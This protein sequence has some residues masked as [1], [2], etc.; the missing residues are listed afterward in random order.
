MPST[1][2]TNFHP[3]SG[4]PGVTW[5][6]ERRTWRICYA[7]EPGKR[8]TKSFNPRHY[9]GLEQALQAAIEYLREQK[10]KLS[11]YRPNGNSNKG[12]NSASINIKKMNE[13]LNDMHH[14]ST[15]VLEMDINNKCGGKHNGSNWNNNIPYN[16]FEYGSGLGNSELSN[17]NGELLPG[18]DGGKVANVNQNLFGLE[19][20][21]E[22]WNAAA[23]AVIAH[24]IT[25]SKSNGV[26]QK[27]KANCE[28]SAS[29]RAP[30]TKASK[31][32]N[33]YGEHTYFN[34][35]S[36]QTNIEMSGMTGYCCE[37]YYN[38]SNNG[39]NLPNNPSNGNSNSKVNDEQNSAISNQMD[40]NMNHV[41]CNNGQNHMIG[42]NSFHH[43]SCSQSSKSTVSTNNVSNSNNNSIHPFIYDYNDQSNVNDLMNIRTPK[44]VN[45][46]RH[47]G[48][49]NLDDDLLHPS[50]A[51]SSP[52]GKVFQSTPYSNIDNYDAI[53]TPDMR[54]GNSQNHSSGLNVNNSGRYYGNGNMFENDG[55]IVANSNK[56]GNNGINKSSYTNCNNNGNNSNNN[57]N[58]NNSG[59]NNT[60]LGCNHPNHVNSSYSSCNNCI[61]N[62]S[63]NDFGDFNTPYSSWFEGL[64]SCYSEIEDTFLN[65]S[66]HLLPVGSL[67]PYSFQPY[68]EQPHSDVSGKSIVESILLPLSTTSCGTSAE[69]QLSNDLILDSCQ[70]I[71]L[72]QNNTT[73]VTNNSSNKS[74]CLNDTGEI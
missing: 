20:S 7:P 43:Y 56:S 36:S 1:G 34:S 69:P 4:H 17:I 63:Q 61:S 44:Y 60:N 30:S 14:S 13:K 51:S 9:G 6:S 57:G 67:G 53:L 39:N 25:T 46:Q 5:C 59:N 41:H 16:G 71:N 10:A 48:N 37:C 65:K 15:S 29:M 49:Q 73:T 72:Y 8:V 55:G 21:S 58:N 54:S 24:A 64:G 2:G 66:S 74:V 22:Q 38:N 40:N 70:N 26:N 68:K 33:L 52:L 31:S 50:I 19:N 18:F 27:R 11:L 23:A 62:V 47:S 12:E 32:S 42:H 45:Y 28:Y 3:Q 35:Q